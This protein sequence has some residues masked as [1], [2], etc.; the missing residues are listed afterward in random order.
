MSKLE[1]K[2]NE[3]KEQQEQAKVLFMKLQGAIELTEGM[4]MDEKNS[5]KEEKPVEKNKK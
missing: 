4:I 2:L 3:L 5:T 1:E